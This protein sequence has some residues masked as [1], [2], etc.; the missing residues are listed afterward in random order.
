MAKFPDKNSEWACFFFYNDWLLKG[1]TQ[2]KHLTDES[3]NFLSHTAFQNKIYSQPLTFFGRISA[4]NH[5]RRQNTK[6]QPKYENC[7]LKFLMSQK[8]SKFI[9]QEIVSKKSERPTACQEK[10][11]RDINL[12]L[13]ESINWKVTHQTSFKCTKSTKL[14]T[15]NFKLLHRQLPTNSF[16]KKKLDLEMM[17]SALSVIGK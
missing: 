16:F 4:V 12:P 6:T 13:N 9:Y 8:P 17:T 1:I 15:F 3:S 7:F 14:I 10:R 11:H 5:L 2:V